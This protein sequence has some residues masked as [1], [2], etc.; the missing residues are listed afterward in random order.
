ME[1]VRREVALNHLIP[2]LLPCDLSSIWLQ[3]LKLSLVLVH[4]RCH[5]P[6]PLVDRLLSVSV[7]F[8]HGKGRCGSR[9][10]RYSGCAD[11]KSTL[12]LW[13][14]L[15]ELG[16]IHREQVIQLLHVVRVQ[17]LER[18]EVH[19]RKQFLHH[20]WVWE[21][22]QREALYY[23]DLVVNLRDVSDHPLLF[24]GMPEEAWHVAVEIIQQD[25]MHLCKPS[26]LNQVVYFP[27][28]SSSRQLG[29]SSVQVVLL[30]LKQLSEVFVFQRLVPE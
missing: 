24:F 22:T 7:F 13:D 2:G 23:G 15:Q 14:E 3:G 30:L 18:G 21:I 4:V 19:C 1:H 17:R 6:L 11:T 20:A 29:N 10:L 27:H 12:L 5:H 28:R 25:G 26:P 8:H 16:Q 9:N